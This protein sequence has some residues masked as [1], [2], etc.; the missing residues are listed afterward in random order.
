MVTFMTKQISTANTQNF[1][2]Q[3]LY[4]LFVFGHDV[5]F[6]LVVNARIH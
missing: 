4:A 5:V 1:L 2:P 3:L 6:A